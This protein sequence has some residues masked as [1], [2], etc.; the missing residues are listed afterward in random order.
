MAFPTGHQRLQ[1]LL[2][3][4][5]QRYYLRLLTLTEAPE[6]SPMPVVQLHLAA[7]RSCWYGHEL[8]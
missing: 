4:H 8:S 7:P 2:Q 6:V 1:L 5:L 3:L